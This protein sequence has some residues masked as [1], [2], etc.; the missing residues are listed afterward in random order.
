MKTHKIVVVTLF[1][2]F[3]A[4]IFIF[5][6]LLQRVGGLEIAQVQSK[7]KVC[8]NIKYSVQTNGLVADLDNNCDVDLDHNI[9]PL[10]SVVSKNGRNYVCTIV[11]KKKASSM[12]YQYYRIISN[13]KEVS[14][15]DEVGFPALSELNLPNNWFRY[16]YLDSGLSENQDILRKPFS[17]CTS[18][19]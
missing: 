19:S 1:L 2:L 8:E 14:I 4:G 11:F 15:G 13:L 17:S 12:D 18:N 7:Q 6:H 5:P 10:S 9:I 3:F 16:V